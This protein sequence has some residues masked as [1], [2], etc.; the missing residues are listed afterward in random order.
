MIDVPDLLILD[1][2]TNHLDLDMIEWLEEYLS[3]KNLTLLLVTHDRYF[4]I[5]FAIKYWS[6]IGAFCILI[7]ELRLFCREEGNARRG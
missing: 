7:R 3:D 6:W 4:W 2:P 5:A 1:E